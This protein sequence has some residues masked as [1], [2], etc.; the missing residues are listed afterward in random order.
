MEDENRS[1]STEISYSGHEI[2]YWRDKD[3]ALKLP[4]YIETVQYRG[5][6]V[7]MLNDDY[8]QCVYTT[9]RSNQIGFGTYNF[10]YRTDFA[11]LVDDELDTVFWWDLKGEFP[12]AVL[13]KFNNAGTMDIKLTWR[14]R[15]LKIW[16]S[17]MCIKK[18]DLIMQ[19]EEIMRGI[20]NGI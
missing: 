5:E 10:S 12:G 20:K 8:G 11:S 19:A 2:N 16:L 15:I 6:T 3:K 17:P 14:S 9:W 4:D 18:E 13:K 7:D 1:I